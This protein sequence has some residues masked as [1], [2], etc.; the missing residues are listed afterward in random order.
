M[1]RERDAL[2]AVGTGVRPADRKTERQRDR[3]IERQTQTHTGVRPAGL[4]VPPRCGIA[5]GRAVG[6][7][8]ERQL[9]V[10]DHSVAVDVCSA[11][12]LFR[13]V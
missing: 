7:H 5:V 1:A 8:C 3:E 2:S 12:G 9:V 4:Q 6:V 10:V 11:Q 13:F